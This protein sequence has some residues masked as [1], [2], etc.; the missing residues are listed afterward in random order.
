MCIHH[1]RPSLLRQAGQ[2]TVVFHPLIG[3]ILMLVRETQH[4]LST[5][6]ETLLQTLEHS[7]TSLCAACARGGSTKCRLS[8]KNLIVIVRYVV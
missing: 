6:K 1:D 8:W 5:E 3:K 2:K 4:T 7:G